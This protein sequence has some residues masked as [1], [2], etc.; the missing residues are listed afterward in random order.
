[1]VWVRHLE[2][3]RQR[4]DLDAPR[5]A[6]PVQDLRLP[7]VQEHAVA[8]GAGAGR[9]SKMPAFIRK[10]NFSLDRLTCFQMNYARV[11]PGLPARAP[12]EEDMRKPLCR[13]SP[14]SRSIAGAPAAFADMAAA[15]KWIDDEFQPSMLSVDEQKA[16]M[17]WFIDAAEPF[18]GMEI[19][20]LSEGIP[21]HNYE[22]EVADQGL[23]GDHRHQGQPPGSSA[24]ARW[25]RRCRP[26]CRPT[27]TSMTATSTT[28]T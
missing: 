26:R 6:G 4:L 14:R 9:C 8:L 22:S 10:S 12:R 21:T 3:G 11:M 5:T 16:E 28:A 24:R 15:E 17:Q 23:R 25:C 18:A 1:M 13:P 7:F 20:V 27:A 2:L 19:N